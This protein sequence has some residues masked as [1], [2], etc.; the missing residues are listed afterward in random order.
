VIS[1]IFTGSSDPVLGAMQ[2]D[3]FTDELGLRTRVMPA[4]SYACKVFFH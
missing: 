3:L 2:E 1:V 4:M